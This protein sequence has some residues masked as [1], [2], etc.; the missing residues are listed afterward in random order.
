[1]QEGEEER[2]KITRGGKMYLSALRPKK[3]V[4]KGWIVNRGKRN[5]LKRE[6]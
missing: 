1:M 2:W 3:R 6:E 5:G 4:K